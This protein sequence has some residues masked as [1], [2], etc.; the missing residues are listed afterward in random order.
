MYG[1]A[2][3]AVLPRFIAR[4]EPDLMAVSESV[5]DNDVW[6]MAHPEFRRDPKVRAT[7]DFLERIGAEP[8]GLC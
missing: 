7:S 2:G 3:V 1:R 8:H 5:A 6:L 4:D